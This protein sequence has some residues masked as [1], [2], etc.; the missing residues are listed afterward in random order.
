MVRLFCSSSWASYFTIRL[1][2]NYYLSLAILQL[3]SFNAG[4]AL[5]NFTIPSF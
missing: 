1:N 2:I 5:P 3:L 4:R